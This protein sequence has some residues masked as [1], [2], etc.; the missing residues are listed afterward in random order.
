MKKV[1]SM[2]FEITVIVLVYGLF[3]RTLANFLSAI[4]SF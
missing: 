4:S 1:I 3:I 2:F